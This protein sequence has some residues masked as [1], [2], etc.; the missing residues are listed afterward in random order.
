MAIIACPK[1]KH[2]VSDTMTECP[3]C[4]I[5]LK[6]ELRFHRANYIDEIYR[7]SPENQRARSGYHKMMV[8]GWILFAIFAPILIAGIVGLSAFTTEQPADSNMDPEQFKQSLQIIHNT[9]Y[10]SLGIFAGV[11][12]LLGLIFIPKAFSNLKR[13]NREYEE[14]KAK[15]QEEVQRE[16]AIM[17]AEYEKALANGEIKKPEEEEEVY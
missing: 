11:P 13:L 4:G 2:S 16:D 1:C 3:F 7:E 17:R 9:G 8:W 12:T 10:I 14:N 6:E 15:R 5:N